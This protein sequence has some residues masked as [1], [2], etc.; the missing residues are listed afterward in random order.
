MNVTSIS[1]IEYK[2]PMKFKEIIK[3]VIS[4]IGNNISNKNKIFKSLS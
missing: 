2:R 3:M 1:V 4:R